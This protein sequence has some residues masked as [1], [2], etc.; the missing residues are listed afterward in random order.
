MRD[1]FLQ[2]NNVEIRENR[3]KASQ[4]RQIKQVIKKISLLC[5]FAKKT[6]SIRLAHLYDI[7][8]TQ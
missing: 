5:G 7:F 2:L 4:N 8:T 1:I 3:R 6:H